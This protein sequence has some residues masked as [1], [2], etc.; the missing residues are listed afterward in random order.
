MKNFIQ[1][2]HRNDDLKQRV[3]QTGKA[4]TEQNSKDLR[5]KLAAQM[6]IIAGENGFPLQPGDFYKQV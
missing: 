3:N 2:V 4:I 1:A 6:A 5:K